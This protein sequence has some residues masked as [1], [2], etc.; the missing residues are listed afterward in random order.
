MNDLADARLAWVRDVLGVRLEGASSSDAGRA[1][2]AGVDWERVRAEWRAASDAVDGQIAALQAALRAD[3]DE[4][5]QRIAE[6]GLNGV[7]GNHRVTLMAAL[8]APGPD[9]TTVI[10]RFRDFLDTDEKIAVC[11]DNPFRVPVSIRATLGAALGRMDA[12]LAASAAV[13]AR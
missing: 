13:G 11:D 5:L 12:A 2:A 6:F 10:R 8:A 1:A 4:T 9:T 3:G 7:T